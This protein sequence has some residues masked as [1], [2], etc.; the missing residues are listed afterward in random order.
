[1]KKLLLVMI[2]FLF[3]G[4]DSDSVRTTNEDCCK[5]HGG[6]QMCYKPVD[7]SHGHIMCKDGYESGCE[8][9]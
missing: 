2:L 3:I 8:C 5:N 9:H 6:P 4:C 1:M 7:S